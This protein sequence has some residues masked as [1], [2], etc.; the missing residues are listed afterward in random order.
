[1]RK[2]ASSTSRRLS[3]GKVGWQLV[4]MSEPFA[5]LRYEDPELQAQVF[6]YQVH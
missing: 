5:S 4:E 2:G 6:A 3:K 1:M